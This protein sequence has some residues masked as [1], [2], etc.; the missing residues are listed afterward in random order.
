MSTQQ[1]PFSRGYDLIE[2]AVKSWAPLTSI[3][4]VGNIR[5]LDDPAYRPRPNNAAADRPEI[6]LSERRIVAQTLSRDSMGAFFECLY[7]IQIKSDRLGVDQINLVTI[8][9]L[10]A[11]THAGPYMGDETPPANVIDKWEWQPAALAAKDADAGRPQ[12]VLI[13]GVNVSF[14]MRRSDFLAASFT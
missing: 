13:G 9:V 8:L 1:N 4:A 5:N 12:W 2:T 3:V 7:P 11:L 14:S 10:Q 6:L